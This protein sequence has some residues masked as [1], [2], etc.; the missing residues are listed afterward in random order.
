V[1]LL[2]LGFVLLGGRGGRSSGGAAQGDCDRLTRA[3]PRNA[4]DMGT[5]RYVAEVNA[6][7]RDGKNVFGA[8]CRVMRA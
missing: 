2:V 4:R 7:D 8:I 3:S 5:G 1:V 6:L